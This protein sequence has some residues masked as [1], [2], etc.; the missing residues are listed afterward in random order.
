MFLA[1]CE[2][3]RWVL[4]RPPEYMC[5]SPNY[6]GTCRYWSLGPT[7]FLREFTQDVTVHHCLS[8]QRRSP[9]ARLLD[10]YNRLCVGEGFTIDYLY[11][12]SE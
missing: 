8:L 3:F 12:E 2:A 9:D 11:T 6:Y 10:R 4:R 1:D 5:F 7:L